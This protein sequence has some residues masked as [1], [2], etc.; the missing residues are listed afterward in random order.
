[1]KQMNELVQFLAQGDHPV[2]ASL[3]P[4]KTL[5]LFKQSVDRG[6]VHIKFTDTRGGTELGVELDRSRS[7]LAAVESGLRSGEVVCVG[8]L[9]LDYVPVTCVAKIDLSTLQG[10][11]HLVVKEV[12]QE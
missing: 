11:G 8:D 10:S 5:E 2:E 4:E 7:N 9:T 6:Y 3:R 1:M 12:S